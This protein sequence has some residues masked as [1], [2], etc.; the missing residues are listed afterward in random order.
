MLTVE[1]MFKTSVICFLDKCKALWLW[2]GLCVHLVCECDRACEESRYVWSNGV[3]VVQKLISEIKWSLLL[4]LNHVSASKKE[5]KQKSPVSSACSWPD[6]NLPIC[7]SVNYLKETPEHI[8]K[9]FQL[10]F[11]SR[12]FPP[13]DID[14]FTLVHKI[15]KCRITLL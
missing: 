15:V 8:Y 10:W 9:G 12:L 6:A 11:Q 3:F 2:S 4:R 7:E 13:W 1:F 5:K 14:L